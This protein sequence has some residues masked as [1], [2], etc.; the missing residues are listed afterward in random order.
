MA[1]TQPVVTCEYEVDVEPI[2]NALDEN[3]R[4]SFGISLE[5]LQSP[6]WEGK[7]KQG[8]ISPSHKAA[9]RLREAGYAG[10][11]VQSFTYS[12]MP[13]DTNLVLWE[14]G[15]TL[16]RKVAVV[17]DENV[18]EQLKQAFDRT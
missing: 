9:E 17:D 10:L 1:R 6:N 13:G 12:A 4:M 11:L 7:M 5:D 16:P 15:N 3:D 18:L 2:F 14:Y 8:L